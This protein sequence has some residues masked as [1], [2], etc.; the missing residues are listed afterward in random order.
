MALNIGSNVSEFISEIDKLVEEH[1]LDVLDAV[2]YYCERNGIEME[3][4]ASIIKQNAKIKSRLQV[5]AENLNYLPK[6]ARLP[7]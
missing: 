4:A 2:V 1:G 5:E 3:T 6:K 7:I